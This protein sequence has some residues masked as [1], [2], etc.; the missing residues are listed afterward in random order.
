MADRAA[1]G[2][3]AGPAARQG[4]AGGVA[5]GQRVKLQTDYGRGLMW[6]KRG[7]DAEETKVAFARLSEF[8]ASAES[9][10]ARFVALDAQCLRYFT[11]GAEYTEAPGAG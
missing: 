6:R 1:G 3:V 9:A 10:A 5:P 11:R 2:T 7:L 4:A 8:E